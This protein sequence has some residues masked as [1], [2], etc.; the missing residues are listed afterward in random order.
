MK[1]CYLYCSLLRNSEVKVN[2]LQNKKCFYNT[3]HE[4]KKSYYIKKF[5][6]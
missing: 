2:I 6:A 4:F 5:R 1:Y 3:Y